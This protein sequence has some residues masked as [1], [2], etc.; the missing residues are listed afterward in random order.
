VG[1][2]DNQAG[3][4]LS[5]LDRLTD[6]E[7]DSAVEGRTSSW[8][9]MRQYKAGLCRDLAALL[10]TRRADEDFDPGY[11]QATNSLLT[12]GVADFTSFNLK[13]GLEQEKV[14][15]SIEQAIRR[16]EPR[17]TR[18]TVILELPDAL[19]PV[20][21]FQIDAMLRSGS[22][23][24]PVLFNATLHHDSRQVAVSGGNS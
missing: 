10:N 6:I 14:R 4:T 23:T 22:D 21:R 17:L 16:F 2:D 24:Q 3:I 5:I 20:L 11:E 1:G 9:E 7:P 18:V 15:R 13:N 8:E 12:F 19:S